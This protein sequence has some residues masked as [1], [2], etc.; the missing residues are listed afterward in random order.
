MT[1]G[2]ENH[3]IMNCMANLLA[4]IGDH[5]ITITP[6]DGQFK[7]LELTIRRVPQAEASE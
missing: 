4:E 2:T 5:Y 6:K 3:N 7:G 1:D